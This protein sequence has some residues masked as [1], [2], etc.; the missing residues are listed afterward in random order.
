MTEPSS[1][2]ALS[3]AA[4]RSILK[5]S[6]GKLKKGSSRGMLAKRSSSESNDGLLVKCF[7][8]AQVRFAESVQ[9]R[10]H[11]EDAQEV[12]GDAGFP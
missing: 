4:M 12:L 1:A 11:K 3:S 5:P 9:E 8:P 2:V 6:P 7:S 10:N